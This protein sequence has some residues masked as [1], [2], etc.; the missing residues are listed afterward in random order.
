M[1]NIYQAPAA[2]LLE[3][4]QEGDFFVTSIHKMLIL[5]VATMSIYALYWFYKQWSS[6][7][8][9][10]QKNIWPFMR[11]FFAVFFVHSLARRMNERLDAKQL[12][13][14]RY[15]SAATW[16][17]VLDVVTTGLSISTNF[18][19]PPLAAIV[20]FDMSGFVALIPLIG[21]QRKANQ[22]SGDPGGQSNSGISAANVLCIVLGL[23]VWAAVLWG[24]SQVE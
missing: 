8:T 6:Q 17:V 3:S 19:E 16:F 24:Y 10:I 12:D 13:T 1:E 21:L 23:L 15:Q 11:A 5:S 4:T 14:S 18:W 9:T 7:R 2:P 22:A 20:A